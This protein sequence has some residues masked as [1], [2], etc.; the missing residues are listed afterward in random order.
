MFKILLIIAAIILAGYLFKKFVVPLLSVLVGLLVTGLIVVGIVL[1]LVVGG[2][3]FCGMTEL[4]TEDGNAPLVEQ[5]E[6]IANINENIESRIENPKGILL[7]V[8][9]GIRKVQN[10]INSK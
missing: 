1:A 2:A 4:P 9:T 6:T 3:V 7:W 5:S 10:K 8:D